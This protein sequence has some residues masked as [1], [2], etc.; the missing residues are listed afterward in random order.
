MRLPRLPGKGDAGDAT[1]R[2]MTARLPR[3]MLSGKSRE[4]TMK[5][6]RR[7]AAGIFAGGCLAAL[8]MPSS[9]AAE[10]FYKGKSITLYVGSGAG[11]AYDT[12]ARLVA[13]HYSQH[14]PGNPN[15]I[16]VDMPGASGRKMIGYLYNVA[17]RDGTAIATALSTLT[18]DPLIG[19][20]T[21]FDAT[22]LSWIGSANRETST[23]IVWH[24]S[25]I[26]T[27]DDVRKQVMTVGSSGPSSTDSIYP[28]VLNYLFG[29]KFKV[30]AGYTSAP[31]M[32]MAIEHG[33][34]DGRCGLTM[35]SLHSV[36]RSWTE[37]RKVR[38][39][40]QIAIE[41][42]P[43]IAD[44]PFIFDLARTAEERQ[45]LT[46]WAAPNKMGRPFYGPPDVPAERLNILRRAFDA[47][48]KDP[49]FR[50]DAERTGLGADG[51]SGEEVEA[52]VKQ[53][54]ATPKDVVVR[55]AQAAKGK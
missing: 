12:Y 53:V 10:D 14:I 52:L 31:L 11:G 54:Y 26:H 5:T 39:I 27:I 51:I 19:G 55:A 18:L 38:I 32:S 30:I 28:N 36:N 9:G 43:Q 37:Q 22:R 13:R 15:I 4:G 35:S 42:D 3:D 16:V 20:D 17:P 2:R 45:I 33:E 44:V 50:A 21:Q 6:V 49:A 48:E 23:C 24:A 40:L 46:L 47:M 7:I 1:Q 8:A 34:L 41:K 29:M 25:P